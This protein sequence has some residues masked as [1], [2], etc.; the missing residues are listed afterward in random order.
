MN[1]LTRKLA[2]LA[3]ATATAMAPT[4]S[5]ADRTAKVLPDFTVFLDPPTGFVFV[6]L[7]RGWKFVGK[8]DAVDAARLPQ[9]VVTA[10]LEGNEDIDAPAVATAG[11]SQ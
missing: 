9:G 4:W 10:L 7:P 3:I 11:Q 8:V 1:T 2:S 5:H 6:K